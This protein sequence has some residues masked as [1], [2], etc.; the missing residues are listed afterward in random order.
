MPNL[1][2]RI[3]LVT[4]GG[5]AHPLAFGL[6]ARGATVVVAMREDARAEALAG[7]I[8]QET[9]NPRVHSCCIDLASLECVRRGAREFIERYGRLH[10][11]VTDAAVRSEWRLG[12]LGPFLLA[13]LLLDTMKQSGGGRVVRLS[14]AS[15]RQ[16]I[17]SATA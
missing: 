1:E 5:E 13:H 12:H 16:H 14:V 4:S 7:R 8:A 10:V 17:W 9:G 11:L 6:A 3:A 2:G 15:D